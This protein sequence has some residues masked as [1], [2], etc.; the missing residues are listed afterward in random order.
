MTR[1]CGGGRFGATDLG[2][3]L[4]PAQMARILQQYKSKYNTLVAFRPVATGAEVCRQVRAA[5]HA[6]LALARVR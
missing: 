5:T 2:A 1:S 3:Q 4:R 6:V